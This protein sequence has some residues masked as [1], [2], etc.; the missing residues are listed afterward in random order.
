MLA[1]PLILASLALAAET[2]LPPKLD[3]QRL[4]NASFLL[5]ASPDGTLV[6]SGDPTGINI[7][8]MGTTRPVARIDLPRPKRAGVA[9]VVPLAISQD[10]ARVLFYRKAYDAKGEDGTLELGIVDAATGKPVAIT[11]PRKLRCRPTDKRLYSCESSGDGVLSPDGKE[12]LYRGYYNGPNSSFIREDYILTE[13]GRLRS[14]AV[15]TVQQDNK[16]KDWWDAQ[17]GDQSPPQYDSKGVRLS[18]RWQGSFC[19]VIE[20]DSGRRRA[21]LEDCSAADAGYLKLSIDGARVT[22]WSRGKLMVWDAADGRVL[23]RHAATSQAPYELD[24]SEVDPYGRYLLEEHELK[25]DGKTVAARL[26]LVELATGKVLDTTE[27]SLDGALYLR[28]VASDGTALFQGEGSDVWLWSFKT[29]AEAGPAAPVAAASIGV[30]VDKAPPSS[31]KTDPDAFAVVIGI[32]RYRQ[33][34][35][36]QVDFASRDAS[37]MRDYLVGSMGYDPR[38]VV[39]LADATATRTDLEKH[40]GKWLRNRVGEKSR[41]FIYYAGHGA[42]DPAT[43]DAYLLPYEAD[44]S[45][46]AET[47]YPL[48]KLKDELGKLPSKDVT[49]VLD[50]C[51]SGQ[52]PRSL[53]AQG[54]RPL[55]MAKP[56]AASTNGQVIAAASASQIS[57][58]HRE[59]RHGLLTYYLL[60]GLHGGADSDQDGS[61]TAAEVFAYASPAV[62]R[63]ARLQNADQ[64]PTMSGTVSARPWVV[65]KK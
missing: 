15:E 14:K 30:D 61:I 64:T 45:Y 2:P 19:S 62:E 36:P 13:K 6:A 55:V 34:G 24:Q 11:S 26:V 27:S 9:Q 46:L 23:H 29:K 59:G 25:K 35:I 43:G 1:F 58:S 20:T 53:I 38:N 48:S 44:P 16:N 4:A 12:A 8:K 50:A 33:S 21:F 40:L 22:G 52:G 28:S 39:F 54:A 60:E 47:A 57:L 41:V 5:A 63:A 56:I 3:L 65:L 42:P 37:S 49:V 17:G 51:F 10:N 31:L 32:E 18:A 7:W